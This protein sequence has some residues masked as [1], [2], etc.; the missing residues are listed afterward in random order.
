MSKINKLLAKFIT[1]PTSLKWAEIEKIL[2]HLNCLKITAKGS[3]LK[4]KH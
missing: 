2:L 4:F 3:H 1:N